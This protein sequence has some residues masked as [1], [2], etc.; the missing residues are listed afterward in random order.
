MTSPLSELSLHGSASADA[1]RGAL[2]PALPGGAYHGAPLDLRRLDPACVPAGTGAIPSAPDAVHSPCLA[3]RFGCQDEW[4]AAICQHLLPLQ[5]RA[6][7]PHSFQSSVLV[8]RLCGSAVVDLRVDASRITRRLENLDEA[9][10]ARCKVMWQLASR[11]RI[12]QGRHSATLEAGMWTICDP[13]RE[14]E[15]SFEKGARVLL[16]L[17]PPQLRGALLSA[18]N[19][20]PALAMPSCGP[21]QIACVALAAVLREAGD[22]DDASARTL[23]DA[24]VALL[25]RALD[26]EMR[27]R[28]VA[29]HFGQPV[30]VAQLRAH[31]LEHIADRT[32]SVEKMA[33]DFG[34]SRRTLYNL[35]T[36]TGETPH[37]FIQHARLERSAR[38]LKDPASRRASIARIARDCGFTDPAHF[39]RA[40]H[41]HYG[42]TPSDWRETAR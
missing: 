31:V 23:H 18:L 42:Q 33:S 17:A 3:L 38:L 2:E 25:D 13:T 24:I 34:I 32:L 41:A 30:N 22:L 29:M 1:T 6:A 36:A 26:S 20:L 35:F 28:G 4:Q 7:D 37:A 9:D 11:S 12:R 19:A 16:F 27:A 21:A 39:S 5:C 14:Y 40:F 15:I 10:G 8:T